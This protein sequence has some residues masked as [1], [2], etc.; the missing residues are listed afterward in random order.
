MKFKNLLL[1]STI[2][3]GAL[4]AKAQT[5]TAPATP[6]PAP[7]APQFTEAQAFEAYGWYIGKNSGLADLEFTQEQ[8]DALIR[9]MMIAKEGKDS[10]HDLQKIGPEI[11]R[12]LRAK[13]EVFLAKMRAKAAAEAEKF[14]AE[15]KAKPG[16]VVL[17][18]G[19]AYEIVKPGAGDYPKATDTVT[20][21]Y[22]GTLTDGKVFDTSLEPREPGAPVTPAEFALNGVIP[23]WTEGLQKINKGGKIKLYVPAALGYGEQGQ[24]AIPPNSTLIFEVELLDIKTPPPPAPETSETPATPAP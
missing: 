12:I 5:E 4:G 18:S 24:G 8:A 19:L 6:P 7:P 20:V 2:A 14:F 13:Q 9:G 21:H 16:V 23:G 17:P 3:L 1:A 15:V 10:P 22:K 11:D